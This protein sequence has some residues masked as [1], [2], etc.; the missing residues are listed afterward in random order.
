MSWF[1]VYI[2]TQGQSTFYFSHC[3]YPD[4]S[5]RPPQPTHSLLQVLGL[6]V[7]AAGGV[8]K[9]GKDLV[10]DYFK[11]MLEQVK[12]D[13]NSIADILDTIAIVMMVVGILLMGFGIIGCCG[14]CC[15]IRCCLLVV[16]CCF[17]CGCGGWVCGWAVG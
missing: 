12:T 14:G 6:A 3:P 13:G 17:G 5:T 15:M 4:D 1:Y 7:A 8:L 16:S 11:D 10:S 9:F 2:Y